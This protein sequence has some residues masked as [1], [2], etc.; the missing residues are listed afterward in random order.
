MKKLKET[1]VEVT[2]K[3]GTEDEYYNISFIYARE[4]QEV[5]LTRPEAMD[6]LSKMDKKVNRFE[7]KRFEVKR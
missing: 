2:T 7:I 5:K 1:K 3:R 4:T 6:L